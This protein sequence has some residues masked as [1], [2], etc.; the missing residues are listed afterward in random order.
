M[1]S[2]LTL[3]A[4]DRPTQQQRPEV[5]AFCGGCELQR[6]RPGAM[7]LWGDEPDKRQQ[8]KTPKPL[9]SNRRLPERRSLAVFLGEEVLFP[10]DDERQRYAQHDV[11]DDQA[12]LRAQGFEQVDLVVVDGDG[13]GQVVPHQ[14]QQGGADARCPSPPTSSAP[15]LRRRDAD[16]ARRHAKDD[17]LGHLRAAGDPQVAE[18][19]GEAHLGALDDQGRHQPK[20]RGK[21]QLGRIKNLGHGPHHKGQEQLHPCESAF[22]PAP[23]APDSGCAALTF[24]SLTGMRKIGSKLTLAPGQRADGRGNRKEP[25]VQRKLRN[26]GEERRQI[27]AHGQARAKARDDAAHNRLR[28]ADAVVGHAQ[29]DVVGPQRG[30]ETPDE[31]ADDHHAIDAGR[32]GWRVAGLCGHRADGLFLDDQPGR[33]G[34]VHAGVWLVCHVW[35]ALCGRGFWLCAGLELLVQLG[36]HDCGSIGD[37]Q[38]G[39]G[40]LV[41]RCAGLLVERAVFA[42]DGGDQRDF[43]QRFW[44][45]GILVCRDQG[46]DGAGFHRAG[47]AIGCGILKGGPVGGIWGAVATWQV[48]DGPFAGGFAALI[49]V[50]MIVGFSFQGTELIGI[51]AAESEDPA[52]NIPR[53]VRQVFW[54]IL[55]FYV[56]AIAVIGSLIPYTDPHLLRNEVGDISV[57][58]FTLVFEKA[59]LLS[60][61]VVMNAV[62]LTSVLSAGN[63]GMYASTRMLYTLACQG[64]APKHGGAAVADVEDAVRRRAGAGVGVLGVVAAIGRG[65]LGQHAQHAFGDVVD[66]GEVA[67]HLAVAVHVNRLARQHGLGELEQRHIRPAPRPIDGKKAQPGGGQLVEVRIGVRHQLV[68]FLGRVELMGD[69]K[70]ASLSAYGSLALPP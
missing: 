17:G 16:G 34:G 37:A 4:A 32:A 29:L 62:V 49:G 15:G 8:P 50:A 28:H 22:S 63:S 3:L 54:R 39:D 43:G 69:Q 67:H 18:G 60:A 41:P 6:R 57:S 52:K 30:R 66:I 12:A 51:A 70:T 59:G 5:A 65:G 23:R 31:H 21:A 58:P 53:A 45:G 38:V 27:A 48:A 68:G 14:G 35:R 40:V 61:A 44:R 2:P 13:G 11:G 46:D 47:R 33:A 10:P 24:C 19:R 56:L 1:D 9:A 26:A 20:Q 55:L 25:G 7:G 42:A 64:M 36:D